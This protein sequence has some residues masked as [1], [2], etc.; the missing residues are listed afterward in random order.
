M[1]HFSPLSSVLEQAWNEDAE[2]IKEGFNFIGSHQLQMW[3]QLS[4]RIF[5]NEFVEEN[6][7]ANQQKQT[8]ANCC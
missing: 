2:Q 6:S 3:N 1:S 7:N 8:Q 5:S 4:D